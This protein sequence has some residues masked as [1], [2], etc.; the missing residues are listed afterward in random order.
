MAVAM[1][2][3]AYAA[4]FV[5]GACQSVSQW[6]NGMRKTA[7]RAWAISA[8]VSA[9]RLMV[10]GRGKDAVVGVGARAGVGS[11]GGVGA[12]CVQAASKHAA[13]RQP[14]MDR[15]TIIDLRASADYS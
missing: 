13:T 7:R 1:L 9:S 11:G 6:V 15:T 10:S 12:S 14:A 4:Y 2:P 5:N 8:W 3:S